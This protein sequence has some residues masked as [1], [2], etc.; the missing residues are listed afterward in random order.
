MNAV[1]LYQDRGLAVVN[2]HADK[3]FECCRTKLSPIILNIAGA[4]MHV[5][6]VER[7]IRT[8]K[9]RVR[10][11]IHGLSFKSYPRVLV[12]GCVT[13]NIKCLNGLPADDGISETMSPNTLVTGAQCPDYGEL[14]KLHF[15]DYVQVHQERRITNNNEPR[16]VGAIALYP[17]GNAQHTW[18]FMSLNTGK[19]LHR[20][21]WTPLPMGEEVIARVHFLAEKEGRKKVTNN[22]NFEWR[23]GIAVA[24]VPTEEN[25]EE[26]P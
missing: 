12:T 7:S 6:E 11:S 9:E 2:I 16:S 24:E 21:N 22:F 8:I 4:G 1:R 17:S 15:G 23:P 13:Y 3:E 14:V 19:R 5:G 10:C 25:Y 26:S 18:H 20:Q